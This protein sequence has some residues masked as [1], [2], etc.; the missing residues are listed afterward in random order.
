MQPTTSVSRPLFAACVMTLAL[1]GPGC[2]SDGVTRE[3]RTQLLSD[4]DRDGYFVSTECAG[5]EVT[6]DD[7][8]GGGTNG[9][10]IVPGP[11]QCYFLSISESGT[12]DPDAPVGNGDGST[13]GGGG[14][15]NPDEQCVQCYDA[16]AQPIGDPEC[17]VV[18][19]D[20]V[21]CEVTSQQPDGTIC[22]ECSAPNAEVLYTECFL[23]P[24][25]C[26]TDAEC[27]TGEHCAVFET[28]EC[29][30]SSGPCPL[31]PAGG[32]TCVAD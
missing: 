22:W 3:T 25:F 32:G 23:P 31:S 16:D 4:L 19:S 29:D 14:G 12:V 15:W 18:S 1:F 13:G 26:A 30:D 21:V 17:G 8:G 27:K 10:V 5:A 6:P 24:V 7:A 9:C 20:P 11:A 2:S 28:P